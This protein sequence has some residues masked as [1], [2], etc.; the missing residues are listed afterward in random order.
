MFFIDPT[1][2]W[3]FV[4][5]LEHARIWRHSFDYE[6]DTEDPRF[7]EHIWATARALN[8]EDETLLF[9]EYG[10]TFKCVPGQASNPSA[11]ETAHTNAK[12][13]PPGVSSEDP[14]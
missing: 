14:A 5:Q 6:S 12:Q 10:L 9:E 13:A 3:R 1:R 2:R 4:G 11:G 8:G 7:R